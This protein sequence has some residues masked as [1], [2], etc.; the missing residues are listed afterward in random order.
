MND[1][2]INFKPYLPILK[3]RQ[4]EYQALLRLDP[5][6]KRNLYP[7]FVIPPVEYDFEEEKLKKTAE[8]HTS[9]I[10]D[11]Y[12][13]K[14]GKQP[15]LIDIDSS[16]HLESVK[17][18]RTIPEYIFDSLE[19]EN[20]IFSPVIQLSY[21]VSYINAV[22]KTWLSQGRGIAFRISFAELA[23]PSSITKML[24]LMTLLSCQPKDVDIIVDFK[25]GASYTPNENVILAFSTI[26]SAIP[27]ITSFKSLYVVGT[28]LDLSK[29]KKPGDV[30]TREDWIFYQNLYMAIG[31][32]FKNLG[33]GDYN[34]E[35]PE[36]LSLDMRLM[37]PAAKI[38][39]SRDNSWHIFKGTS[40]RKDTS[41][42][43]GLCIRV[44][45]SGYYCGQTY[46]NGDKKI[47]DCASS[48]CSNGN[49]STWK[50]AAISHHLTHVVLQNASLYGLQKLP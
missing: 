24:Q 11:R 34:V 9:T 48:L 1:K 23:N 17:D 27:D 33:F 36:F 14:W 41:Q 10:A 28:S 44:I 12:M 42:M 31:T 47:Y 22:N 50:E 43:K 26:V 20:A 25:K 21:S 45:N 8:E 6:I 46:S 3:W 40:F 39:Y 19:K 49:L 2:N 38:V 16:L 7:L 32:N 5:T 4:G 13:K 35:T 37:N 18:G 29:V 30:Q 15:S